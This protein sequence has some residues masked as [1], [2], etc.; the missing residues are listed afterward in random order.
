M[1]HYIHYTTTPQLWVL[2]CLTGLTIVSLSRVIFF[3]G[4]WLR[5]LSKRW[6][7]LVQVGEMPTGP[8]KSVHT[9][10]SKLSPLLTDNSTLSVEAFP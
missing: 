5:D 8:P 2:L 1:S 4:M 7:L 3:L 6:W 9:S 10:T